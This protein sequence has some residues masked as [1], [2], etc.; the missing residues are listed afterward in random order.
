MPSRSPSEI[1]L[2]VPRW[3]EEEALSAGALVNA[4][5]VLYASREGNLEALWRW[6]P[7]MYR[8]EPGQPALLPDMLPVT[9][10]EKNVRHLFGG[11]T[12]DRMRK[13]AYAA[14]GYRCEICGANG[15]LEAHEAW[16]LENETCKQRLVGILALCP[17][18]HACHHVGLARR[19]GVL[20]E[21]LRHLQHVNFWTVRDA[22][23]A[24]V[25]TYEVWEQRCEWPWSVDLTW[26]RDSGYLNV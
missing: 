3:N 6:L 22:E 1:P 4:E 21:I 24:L 16:Q 13:H 23:A 11:A 2:C 15:R 19:R 9:T 25:E 17:N 7:R 10:W 18:C 5:K 26:L 12:W 14:A 20:P 8:V